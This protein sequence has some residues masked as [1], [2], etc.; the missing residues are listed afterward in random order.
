LKSLLPKGKITQKEVVL[1]FKKMAF[2]GILRLRKLLLP[3][4]IGGGFNQLI[5]PPT[6]K[7]PWWLEEG[8]MKI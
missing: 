1:L 4:G 3:T 5:R 6:V 8:V 2:F 7:P